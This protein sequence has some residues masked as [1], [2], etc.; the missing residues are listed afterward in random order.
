MINA[1][2]GDQLNTYRTAYRS[3]VVTACQSPER[4]S[5]LDII[6]A[7]IAA[8]SALQPPQQPPQSLTRFRDWVQRTGDPRVRALVSR[9]LSDTT[10]PRYRQVFEQEVYEACGYR[11][12][13][14]STI[15]SITLTVNGQTVSAAQIQAGQTVTVTLN[16]RHLPTA[17]N[18]TITIL[19]QSGNLIEGLTPQN[20]TAT[21]TGEE[22][23][24][25]TFTLTIPADATLGQRGIRV[26]P[27]AEC[28]TSGVSAEECAQ[29]SVANPNAFTIIAPVP[30]ALQ[31]SP[32]PSVPET[33]TD[34]RDNDLDGLV[35]AEDPDCQGERQ[36]G[37]TPATPDARTAYYTHSVLR[38]RT[39]VGAGF[40]SPS[41]ADLGSVDQ[42]GYDRSSYVEQLP[43]ASFQLTMGDTTRE[44]GVTIVGPEGARRNPLIRTGASPV[45]L[46]GDFS[47]GA[48]LNYMDRVTHQ[49]TAGLHLEPRFY[50]NRQAQGLF[51][52][53]LGG[54]DFIYRSLS[55]PSSLFFNGYELMESGGLGLGYSGRD[56]SVRAY[57][58]YRDHQFGL[59]RETSGQYSGFNGH[60]RGVFVGGIVDVALSRIT[61]SWA[62][63]LQLRVGGLVWGQTYTPFALGD[64]L[65]Y[66]VERR[67]SVVG[68]LTAY[69]GNFF[70]AD[71]EQTL[72]VFLRVGFITLDQSP[73]GSDRPN[74]TSVQVVGGVDSSVAGRIALGY[75]HTDRPLLFTPGEAQG[76]F[77]QWTMPWL[78]QSLTLR[79]DMVVVGDRTTGGAQLLFDPVAAFTRTP[80]QPVRQPLPQAATPGVP[81]GFG[82]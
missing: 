49:E 30:V 81:L 18:A 71:A 82:F 9:D 14:R 12:V 69:T 47:A 79:G 77:L 26:S 3:Q 70:P 80:A 52:D 16:G 20:L 43:T 35:D 62:P 42:G 78:H 4:A 6:N 58:Q 19:D 17:E 28:A 39:P 61:R 51:I 32:P 41:G 1:M 7:A 38:L 34:H 54:L 67:S 68:D 31:V 44:D 59:D 10:R 29:I 73:E 36:A 11:Q 24:S 8:F 56:W 15:D 64:S 63:D 60:R 72:R 2:V 5:F 55:S 53:A 27:Q 40:I 66:S 76:G 23:T 22:A 48:G 50:F 25:L 65:D 46:L 75:F 33:C 13:Y 57:G 21:M 45:V 74:L 37:E